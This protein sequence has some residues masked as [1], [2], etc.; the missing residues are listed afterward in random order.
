MTVQKQRKNV[1]RSD[2]V[3][4][5]GIAMYWRNVGFELEHKERLTQTGR[6]V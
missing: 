6:M 2:F 3:T 4:P 5:V 1:R